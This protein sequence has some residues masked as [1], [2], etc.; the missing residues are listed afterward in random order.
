M[1]ISGARVTLSESFELPLAASAAF[2]LFTAR[3]EALWV[4]GWS[5]EFFGEVADDI[6]VG[7]VFRTR[8][9]LGRGTTWIVVGGDRGRRIAYARVVES[10]SAGTVTVSLEGSASGCLV[11]VAYDITSTD[12]EGDQSL[13]GFEEGY[14]SY[15]RSWRDLII[16][17]LDSGGALPPA[18]E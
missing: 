4:P 6:D 10:G 8:D 13:R 16:A 3:G 17:H 5:P 1:S 9:T 12:H 18:T 7:T 11:T 14:P 15:I 2:R